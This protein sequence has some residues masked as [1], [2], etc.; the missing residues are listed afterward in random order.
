MP[1]SAVCEPA[2]TGFLFSPLGRAS[3]GCVAAAA[4]GRISNLENALT[5]LNRQSPRFLLKVLL[6]HLVVLFNDPFPF[7]H[8]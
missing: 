5:H 6:V 7:V 4:V 2:N 8:A 3:M 1:I